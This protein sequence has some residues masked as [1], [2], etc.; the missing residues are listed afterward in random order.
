MNYDVM[1]DRILIAI[2]G[3]DN[4]SHVYHCVTRLRFVLYDESL[5]QSDEAM[6][7]PDV[8]GVFLRFG[9]YQFVIGIE[10][11]EV[12]KAVMRRIQ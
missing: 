3:R 2:G 4:I 10:V 6:M 11:A 9:E 7:I 5:Y 8:S 1:S 12:Y